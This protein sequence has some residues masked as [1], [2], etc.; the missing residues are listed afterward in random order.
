[1][2]GSIGANLK[3]QLLHGPGCLVHL[4]GSKGQRSLVS[5]AGH[6]RH[7]QQNAS[8]PHGCSR[9]S[10]EPKFPNPCQCRPFYREG[11]AAARRRIGAEGRALQMVLEGSAVRGFAD[12][13]GVES[14][15][16]LLAN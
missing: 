1:M 10:N 6:S 13:F 2:P 12:V 9:L 11:M 15:R 5:S 4:R 14:T 3:L 7:Y 8:T 16:A